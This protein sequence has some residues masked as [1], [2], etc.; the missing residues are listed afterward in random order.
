MVMAGEITIGGFVAFNALI[1]TA[2]AAV[3]RVL[4]LWDE[5]QMSAVLLDRL[6]TPAARGG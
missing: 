2:Y 3:V 4:S 1:A 6:R 5:W